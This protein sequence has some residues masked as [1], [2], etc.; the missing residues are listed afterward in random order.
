MSNHRYMCLICTDILVCLFCL[1]VSYEW[2]QGELKRFQVVPLNSEWAKLFPFAIF[3]NFIIIIKSTLTCT[4]CWKNLFTGDF[5]FLGNLGFLRYIVSK[6]FS[7]RYQ[8]C[9]NM[10]CDDHLFSLSDKKFLL[11]WIFRPLFSKNRKKAKNS[12]LYRLWV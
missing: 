3:L 11:Q 5:Y 2:P 4:F 12:W 1:F 9:S 10:V 6:K 8:G 7:G